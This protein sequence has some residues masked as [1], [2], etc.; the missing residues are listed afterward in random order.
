MALLARLGDLGLLLL[1]ALLGGFERQLHLR[2]D[3][4]CSRHDAAGHVAGL[5]PGDDRLVDDLAGQAVGHDRLEPIAD[6]DPHLALVRRDEEDDAVAHALLP[7][8]PGAA[9][10]IAV[11]LDVIALEIGDGRDDELARRG[12]LHIVRKLGELGDL[13]GREQVRVVDHAAGQLGEIGLRLGR[14]RHQDQQEGE[15]ATQQCHRVISRMMASLPA[16]MP[17]GYLPSLKRGRISLRMISPASS[18]RSAFSRP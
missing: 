16:A 8:P 10:L 14:E 1:R 18:S 7:D 2:A 11:A 6:F 17:S 15:Q 5:E 12:L 4:L 3:R 13:L 9:E